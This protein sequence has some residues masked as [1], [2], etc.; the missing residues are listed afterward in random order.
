VENIDLFMK[1]TEIYRNVKWRHLDDVLYVANCGI[2]LARGNTE[3][4]AFLDAFLLEL[5]RSGY[6][7]ARWEHWFGAPM[8]VPVEPLAAS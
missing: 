6:V 1:F 7:N 3:L 8:T 5:H 2:G 4:K